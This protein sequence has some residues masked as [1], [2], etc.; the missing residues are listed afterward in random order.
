MKMFKM[1]FSEKEPKIFQYLGLLHL[2]ECHNEFSK[3]A[4]LA[5]MAQCGHLV[6][7]GT[8]NIPTRMNHKDERELVH[9][10]LKLP[11]LY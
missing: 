4:Q 11:Q 6:L 5:R 1:S 7:L 9:A 8:T 10:V 3:V 2:P